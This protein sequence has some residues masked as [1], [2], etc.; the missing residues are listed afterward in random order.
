MRHLN[1][2]SDDE[3][4]SSTAVASLAE[5]EESD[6]L[7]MLREVHFLLSIDSCSSVD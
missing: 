7:V 1:I 6:S 3:S 5:E 2:P 4:A